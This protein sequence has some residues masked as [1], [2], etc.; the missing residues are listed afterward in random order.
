[1]RAAA[2]R[3]A[4]M[5][6]SCI[7]WLSCARSASVIA[8]CSLTPTRSPGS[9]FRPSSPMRPALGPCPPWPSASIT[10]V[11]AAA[12]SLERAAPF[13]TRSLGST[14]PVPSRIAISRRMPPAMLIC[15]R[16]SAEPRTSSSPR[17][18]GSSPGCSFLGTSL[19]ARWASTRAAVSGVPG[20][21][22]SA[23]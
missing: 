8:T 10:I 7:S 14:T 19:C 3:P 17:G 6:T 4:C 18:V 5:I 23:T 15:A 1:M 12:S 21:A 16:L 11:A 2:A 22:R 20:W 9:S 13:P